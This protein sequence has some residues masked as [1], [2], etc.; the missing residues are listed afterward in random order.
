M[1]IIHETLSSPFTLKDMDEVK[2]TE[3]PTAKP[4]TNK[5][6]SKYQSRVKDQMY[7]KLQQERQFKH[8]TAIVA[9]DVGCQYAIVIILA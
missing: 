2:T 4:E 8:L 1:N 9:P 7:L 3:I 5:K 6:V